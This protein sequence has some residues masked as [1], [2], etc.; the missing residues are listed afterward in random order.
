MRNLARPSS[1]RIG[2]GLYIIKLKVARGILPLG[3]T[4]IDV[5]IRHSFSM[6]LDGMAHRERGLHM[7]GQSMV[8][9]AFV[10]RGNERWQKEIRIKDNF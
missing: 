8:H 4:K 10:I 6:G 5:I 9:T 3:S 2:K 7:I 1:K